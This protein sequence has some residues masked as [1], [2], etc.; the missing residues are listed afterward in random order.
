[1][2]SFS[3]S[4]TYRLIDAFSGQ[5]GKM[6]SAAKSL[7]KALDA[8]GKALDR[9]ERQAHSLD[10]AVSKVGRVDQTLRPP[11]AR[12]W[13]R[14]ADAMERV[15]H[16]TTRMPSA[17]GPMPFPGPRVPTGPRV[18]P[19]APRIPKAPRVPHFAP[20]PAAATGATTVMPG[21]GML[22]GGLLAGFGAKAGF[23]ATVG[24]AMSF[25]ES[26]ADVAKVLD[27]S[28][29]KLAE[30]KTNIVDMSRVIPRSMEELSTIMAEAA[31]GG[32][33]TE[34]LARFTEFAGKSSTAFDMLAGDVGEAF[35]KIRNNFKYSQPALEQWADSANHLSNN[36]S[37][38]A[39]EIVNFTKRAAGSADMLNL[40]GEQMNAMGA[41][42]IAAGIVP[43]TAA[44]GVS[45]LANN[46]ALVIKNAGGKKAGK[47]KGAF[48]S[49][50]LNVDKWRKL[51]KEDG[52]KAMMQL[53]EAASKS[54]NGFLAMNELVGADFSDDF[55]KLMKNPELLA[56]AFGLVSDETKY[57][58]S[59]SDE[60][61]KRASTNTNK[62]KRMF[63][64][65]RAAAV[66]FGGKFS[67]TVGNA[68][69]TFADF[70]NTGDQRVSIFDQAKASIDGF[71]A[72]LGLLHEGARGDGLFRGVLTS[73]FGDT[74]TFQQDVANLAKTSNFF[75]SIGSSLKWVGDAAA[76]AAA[77]L[78]KLIGLQPGAI[79][80]TIMSVAGKG[81]MM[82]A[83]GI[84][85]RVVGGSVRAL[86]S[87]L[88][89][90][91]GAR[92]GVGAIRSLFGV[93]GKL[94]PAKAAQLW[95]LAA[96]G[97]SL[98]A[99]RLGMAGSA[100]AGI[101]GLSFGAAAVGLGALAL[102]AGAVYVAFQHWPKISEALA[103]IGGY[104]M[105]AASGLKEMASGIINF[106][107]GDVK[108]GASDL[109]TSIRDI[110]RA[111]AD[112][113]S[114]FAEGALI[115][116]GKLFNFDGAAVYAQIDTAIQG[117]RDRISN[118][119][120]SLIA[121]DTGSDWFSFG[122]K[123]GQKV[124]DSLSGI[125]DGFTW[126]SLPEF[127]GFKLL[128]QV[129]DGDWAGVRSTIEGLE[130]P[131]LSFLADWGSKITSAFKPFTNAISNVGELIDGFTK[132]LTGTSISTALNNFFKFDDI[133][134]NQDA[135][136][137]LEVVRA[138]FSGKIEDIKGLFSGF[139]WDL[140]APDFSFITTAFD[141]V[142]ESIQAAVSTITDA[143]NTLKSVL[144]AAEE[145]KVSDAST[146]A[147]KGALAAGKTVSPEATQGMIGTASAAAGKAGRVAANANVPAA[148]NDNLTAAA[149]RMAASAEMIANRFANVP[150]FADG[151]AGVQ[152]PQPMQPAPAADATITANVISDVRTTFGPA[153]VNVQ[154]SISAPASI[155]LNLPNGGVAG[156]VPLSASTSQPK[157]TNMPVSGSARN[158]GATA[159]ASAR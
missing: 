80:A 17:V 151:V 154:S 83:A 68:A 155:L 22:G 5:A 54:S 100:L 40:S 34:D 96:A 123:I 70:L 139:S 25:E 78:E 2:S 65:L 140:P 131:D 26:F 90:I 33:K 95:R 137:R 38:K 48:E 43:E 141:G 66:S 7:E 85:L 144:G 61:A 21:F 35:A 73:I 132:G 89:A 112:V 15:V 129:I 101:A 87:A 32:T 14:S 157:G 146:S 127:P 148:T 58:G 92:A 97:Q 84:A 110:H 76:S 23:D 126:P 152:A 64:S 138:G 31:Q 134:M 130:M 19:P 77:G 150:S 16:Q 116:I 122:E 94:N 39:G 29:A 103:P 36:M 79:G 156:S 1:M 74:E 30:F 18:P 81:A 121:D 82:M 153:T 62:V 59:V 47:I 120:K 71:M 41:S 124:R 109:I 107:F 57:A 44:R 108:I 119:F 149:N 88:Y 60:F 11:S 56:Q 6:A 128:S 8:S 4:Y 104:A 12:A 3:V 45:M 27:V 50:G 20:A 46:L 158:G 49:I 118:G 113:R 143:W 37:A 133:A 9:F 98:A 13:N 136:D 10:A 67:D 63:N 28:D 115:E 102:A 145:P 135:I 75:R 24:A 111:F 42:M 93:I 99:V 117:V 159:S 55:S 105:D 86:A 53:F 51:Q 106:D 147:L 142:A 91:S 125:F 69:N 52:P 72:G 114:A